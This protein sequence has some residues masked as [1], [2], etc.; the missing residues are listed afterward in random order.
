PDTPYEGGKFT[1]TFRFPYEFPKCPPKVNFETSIF[2]PNINH[3]GEVCLEIL[4]GAWQPRITIS[5]GM[6]LPF[7]KS[8]PFTILSLMAYPLSEGAINPQVARMLDNSREQFNSMART[9]TRNYAWVRSASPYAS[10]TTTQSGVEK[11][12]RSS[13]DSKSSKRSKKSKSPKRNKK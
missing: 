3:S 7:A 8:L 12:K 1:V 2:H 11:D 9:W 5:K 13:S 6:C 4:H 10:P